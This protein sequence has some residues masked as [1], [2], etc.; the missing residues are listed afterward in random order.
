MSF[1][2]T[3]VKLMDGQPVRCVS[4]VQVYGERGGVLKEAGKF[5]NT[6]TAEKLYQIA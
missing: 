5:F 3:E 1:T 4:L 6:V 2:G